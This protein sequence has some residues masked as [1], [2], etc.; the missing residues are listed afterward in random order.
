MHALS[1]A[2]SRE[3]EWAW[4]STL[5][6]RRPHLPRAGACVRTESMNVRRS[7]RERRLLRAGRSAC[8]GR[9]LRR[10]RISGEL[11]L[12]K[13]VC[14]VSDALVVDLRQGYDASHDEAVA[15]EYDRL[16]DLRDRVRHE[17]VGVVGVV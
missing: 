8:C 1:P 2:H 11:R 16:S 3:R 17:V 5:T 4:H 15:F 14:L 10:L 13:D 9:R 7:T 12:A 6:A